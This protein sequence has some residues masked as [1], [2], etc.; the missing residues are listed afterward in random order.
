[1]T[2]GSQ[3]RPA[4]VGAI[5]GLLY[6]L[7]LAFLSFGAAGAGHGTL[8]PLIVSSAPLG[9]TYPGAGSDTE[10]GAALFTMLFAGPLLW[11]LLGWLVAL[12]G[13]RTRVAAAVLLLHY[14]S[15]LALVAT[16]GLTL[17]GMA[18]EIPDFVLAWAP[19]YLLGQ[20]GLWWRII[21][22]PDQAKP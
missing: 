15:A 1:M 4:V 17:R 19:A 7:L 3:W 14:A 13:R 10:R 12:P 22:R 20:V 2:A 5:A 9:V 18:K 6:G 11:M 21:R 8:I 16:T